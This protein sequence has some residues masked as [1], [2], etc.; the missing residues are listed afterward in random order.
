MVCYLCTFA[1]EGQP[2]YLILI[3]PRLLVS[4]GYVIRYVLIR[5]IS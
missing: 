4:L 2:T 5:I 3:T 1:R